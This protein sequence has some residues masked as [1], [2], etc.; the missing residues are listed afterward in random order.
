MI[1]YPVIIPTLNRIK[2]LKDCIESLK[3][4]T[5][6]SETELVIG[7]DFPVTEEHK[8]GWSEINEYVDNLDGFKKITVFKHQQNLGP[9]KNE[10]F[11]REY[12]F[13][14]YD[15]Y[16][17]TE[18]D[19]VFSP[20]F[21]DYMNKC[22]NKYRDDKSIMFVCGYLDPH[23]KNY[24]DKN[25]SSSSIIKIVGQMSAYG[26]GTWKDRIQYIYSFFE[27]NSFQ[28]YVFSNKKRILRLLTTAPVKLNHIYFWI[29][30]KR[31]L[32]R[33]CDFTF[34]SLM[35]LENKKN[36]IPNVYLVKNNGYDGS[37]VN[38]GINTDY[39]RKMDTI[40]LSTDMYFNFVDTISAKQIKELSLF[41][42]KP[43]NSTEKKEKKDIYRVAIPF[44]IFGYNFM[45]IY[46]TVF[47]K[48][49]KYIKSKIRGLL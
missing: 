14:K 48:L 1:F 23:F 40:T 20:C 27:K 18:D 3:H 44:L 11:L 36:I 47:K 28:R 32:D 39:I 41:S 4:N 49:K 2:H 10:S 42:Y 21:L 34:N 6:A 26:Y 13:S 46:K 43:S 12:A 19:N 31:E 7:L 9:K 37:G 17:F 16:I 24:I 8:I 15:A 33:P 45:N 5:Y 25:I 35:V 22:L 30:D 38:C 29:N